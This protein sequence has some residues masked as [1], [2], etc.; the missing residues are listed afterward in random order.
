MCDFLRDRDLIFSLNLRR[1]HISNVGAIALID[2]MVNHDKTLTHL[3][4][5][6]N[7]ITR[8]GAAAFL[9]AM[10]KLTRIVDFQI[11]YGNPIPL[12]ISLAIGYEVVANNQ[13]KANQDHSARNNSHVSTK[14][15]LTSTKYELIDRGPI[16]M[17][18]AIKSVE[19]LKIQHLSLP[20][21]M[22]GLEEAK[23]LADMIKMNP[24]LTTLN[25]EINNLDAQ[26]GKLIADALQSNDNLQI[27]NVSKNLLSDLGIN[28]LLQSLVKSRLVALRDEKTEKKAIEA[29]EFK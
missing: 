8:A 14:M 6:R 1:N 22:L 2:L 25:L 10:K 11:A 17:R 3:D 26:C 28:Y 20:D 15:T 4:V 27:L 21:N 9:T 12:E 19:L 29:E 23:M 16:Y 24:P 7:R 13:I 18:C 5:S